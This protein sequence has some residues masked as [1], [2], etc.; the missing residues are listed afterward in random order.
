[1]NEFYEKERSGSVTGEWHDMIIDIERLRE[2]LKEDD[3][4]AF[5][6][7][8]FGGAMME[9]FEIEK[10]SLEELIRIARNKGIDLDQ[11]KCG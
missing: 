3:Y 9:S 10:A 6:A 7:G 11:Y 1:M 5:F 4:G 2:D 8:G